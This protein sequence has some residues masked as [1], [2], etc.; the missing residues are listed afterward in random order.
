MIKRSICILL[1]L[2]VLAGIGAVSFA[3]NSGYGPSSADL[4]MAGGKSYPDVRMW[5]G[6]QRIPY[7]SCGKDTVTY[8]G[9]YISSPDDLEWY[10]TE[11]NW[12]KV[13]EVK[14]RAYVEAL[15]KEY[16]PPKEGE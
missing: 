15:G 2:L 5:Y 13:S 1:T 3:D 9:A 6:I 4:D 12:K 8:E 14:I 16:I 7:E 11:E 10:W